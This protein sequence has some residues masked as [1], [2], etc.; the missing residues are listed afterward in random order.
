MCVYGSIWRPHTLFLPLGVDTELVFALRVAV[1][2]IWLDFRNCHIWAW[3][4]VIGQS[5]RGCTI[6]FLSILGVQNWPYFRSTGSRF[7][8]MGRF[9]KLPHLGMKLG[10]WPKFQK[11]HIYLQSILRGWNW[12]YFRSMGI[13]SEIQA[14]FQNCHIW[15]WNL[16]IGQ[17]SKVAHRPS[18]YPKGSKLSLFLLY[19]QPFL[20]YRPIFKIAIFGHETWQVAKVPEVAHIHSFYPRGAKIT[21]FMLYGTRFPRYGP[22]FKIAILGHETWQG[23]KVPEVAHI[24]S[25]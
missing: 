5:A 18:F 4:L 21:L 15:A 22:I 24:P 23:S 8:Y 11:L 16:A 13:G 12:A 17:S 19:G 1:S 3:N 25:F 7:R 6:Y 2:E 14:D 9:S 20:K 10:K